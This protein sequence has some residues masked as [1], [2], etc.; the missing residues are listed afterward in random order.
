MMKA[1]IR[2]IAL[3]LLLGL[4]A[5]VYWAGLG[6]PFLLDDR[7]NLERLG[8]FGGI[9]SLR[10]LL[11]YVLTGISSRLGRPLT[12]LTFAANAQNWPADPWWFKATNLALHLTNAALLAHL[13]RRLALR[14]GAAAGAATVVAL[15]SAG[16]WLL[17]PIQITAVL[18]VSQRMVLV[19]ALFTLAG[20]IAYVRGRELAVRRPTA[21]L[22]LQSAGIGVGGT[23]AVL[24]KETGILLPLFALVL[25]ATLLRDLPRPRRWR[26]WAVLFLWL[27]LAALA[28]YLVLGWDDG[29]LA[30]AA[31]LWRGWITQARVLL[32]YLGFVFDPFRYAPDLFHDDFVASRGLLTPPVTLAA[33]A[34]MVALLA[35]GWAVRR[36]H[37]VLGL[38]ILWFFAGHALASSVPTLAPVFEYRNYVPLIGPTFAVAWYGA[39]CARR[40]HWAAGPVLVAVLCAGLAWRT[41]HHAVVWG[42]EA[43]LAAAWAARHPASSRAQILLSG[44]YIKA[45]DYDHALA[46]LEA[47]AK[48]MPDSLSVQL[49]RLQLRCLAHN[50][51]ARLLAEVF[52]DAAHAEF[53]FG[54]ADRLHRLEDWVRSGRCPGLSR[55]NLIELLATLAANPHYQWELPQQRLNYRRAVLLSEIPK[56]DAAIRAA[57]RSLAAVPDPTVAYNAARWLLQSG[58][59]QRARAYLQRARQAARPDNAFERL[60]SVPSVRTQ[61]HQA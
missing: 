7:I 42:D 2:W 5:A 39:Q 18:Y 31:E 54:N 51:D 19:A 45:K 46:V 37:P 61:N 60:L 59:P 47:A 3:A 49:Q 6:G 12:L 20:L 55:R 4:T 14:A 48:R 56:T 53:Q 10:D 15:G 38:A 44:V 9:D 16:L 25:E 41:A 33:V 24:G 36:R 40:W 52:A 26:P 57:D 32:G 11:R 13:A 27:P 43:R 50:V 34:V 35:T 8:A 29:L 30:G 22:W 23:L 58:Q 28:G 21:G 1:G 17:H